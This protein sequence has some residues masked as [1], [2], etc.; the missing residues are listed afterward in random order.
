M[1]II[2]G[3]IMRILEFSQNSTLRK[4]AAGNEWLLRKTE[5][6]GRNPQ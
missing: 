5:Y 6:T 3:I 4:R 1:T 2:I